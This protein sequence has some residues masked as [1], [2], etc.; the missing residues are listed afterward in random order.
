MVHTIGFTGKPLRRFIELLLG[1]GVRTVIDVRLRNTGQ[2]SGWAK[3]DDLAFILETFGIAYQHW[4]ELAP[5]AELLDG[6]R[7]DHDW[8]WYI[9]EYP[10]IMAERAVWPRLLQFLREAEGPCFLCSEPEPD[11][12]H[13]R[14]L[15]EELAARQPGLQVVHLQ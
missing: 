3:R 11:H 10:R 12:C 2:L 9:Q 4:P 5:T 6:F 8:Q 7:A 1:A 13:R 15:C 14:L